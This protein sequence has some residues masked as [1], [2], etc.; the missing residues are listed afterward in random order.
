[1]T[2]RARLNIAGMA[3]VGAIAALTPAHHPASASPEPV[4]ETTVS[5]SP[6]PTL[7]TLPL[8]A[9]EDS[10]NCYWDADVLGNGEGRSFIDINGT[11]YYTTGTPGVPVNAELAA[12]LAAMEPDQIG[13]DWTACSLYLG[14]TSTIVCPDGFT[15]T[16]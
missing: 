8:C 4:V 10:R 13:R 14:D 11:A 2:T 7:A 1:M 16:S 3:I 5:P 9:E 12:G 15:L 6:R